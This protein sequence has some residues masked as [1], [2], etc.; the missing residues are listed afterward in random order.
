MSKLTKYVNKQNLISKILTFFFRTKKPHFILFLVGEDNKVK[1]KLNVKVRGYGLCFS[2]KNGYEFIEK[3][4]KK[5]HKN[6]I[7]Y[8]KMKYNFEINSMEII[9]LFFLILN[10]QIYQLFHHNSCHL[11]PQ[12]LYLK[13]LRMI[14]Y[15]ELMFSQ[16]V[17]NSF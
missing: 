11:I 4:E 7:F 17:C 1:C 16:I 9:L 2:Y 15:L 3:G 6:E 13:C 8:F 14:A 5:L 10:Q 12:I